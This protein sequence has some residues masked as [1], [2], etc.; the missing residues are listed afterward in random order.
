M[1]TLSKEQILKPNYDL[2]K[3][4]QVPNKLKSINITLE[5]PKVKSNNNKLSLLF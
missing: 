4:S 1:T 3:F 5:S 2:K